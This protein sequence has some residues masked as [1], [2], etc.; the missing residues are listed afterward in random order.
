M[1]EFVNPFY[2]RIPECNLTQEELIRAIRPDLAAEHEAVYAYMVHA[3]A[4]DDP[5]AKAVRVDI[6]NEERVHAGEFVRLFTILT[7]DEDAFYHKGALEVDALTAKIARSTPVT[8]EKNIPIIG[9]LKYGKPWLSSSEC[10]RPSVFSAHPVTAGY[11][12]R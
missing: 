11:L 10:Q 7:G 8:Q 12:K 2:G 6:A 3:E 5:V 9:S 4:T 1:P